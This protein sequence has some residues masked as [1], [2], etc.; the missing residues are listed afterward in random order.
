M[1][2]IEGNGFNRIILWQQLENSDNEI[3]IKAK[4]IDVYFLELIDC[5]C[6]CTGTLKSTSMDNLA[7]GIGNVTPYFIKA[8]LE[9]S[10]SDE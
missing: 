1:Y 6:R 2:L 9:R 10:L 3:A 7:L 5:V 8:Q 4:K